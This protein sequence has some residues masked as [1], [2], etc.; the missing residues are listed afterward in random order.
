M[1]SIETIANRILNSCSYLVYN[2]DTK[3]A[4]LF[5]CGDSQPIIDFL[6][7]H[8]LELESV[9]ITHSH[10][11]HI[12]G[13]NEIIAAYPTVKVYCS[14]LTLEGIQNE[15]INLS[16]MHVD[17]FTYNGLDNTIII[18][19]TS[20][21]TCLGQQLEI[22]ETPGHDMD[23]LSYILADML[24]SGDCFSYDFKVFVKW[25]RS[26]KEQALENE[27]KLAALTKERNLR[28]YPGHIILK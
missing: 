6:N 2:T 18:D 19:G 13:I 25:H 15:K 11:D 21:V 5:D 17:D 20:N 16:Y 22:L 8:H 12:Y 9:F 3:K 23:C 10:F 26:N 24:F 27:A 7:S 1:I 4:S 14:A 28:V